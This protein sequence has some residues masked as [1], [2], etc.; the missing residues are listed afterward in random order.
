MDYAEKTAEI[1]NN[2]WVCELF[3]ESQEYE[4]AFVA[5]HQKRYPEEWG[6]D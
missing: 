4:E 5:W 1:K 3:R 6:N 2:I